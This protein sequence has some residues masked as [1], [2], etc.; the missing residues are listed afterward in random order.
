M[1]HMYPFIGFRCLYYILSKA[2]EA[3]LVLQCVK[4]FFCDCICVSIRMTSVQNN[5]FFF[6]EKLK[7]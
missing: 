7:T 1:I 3:I 2:E 6:H 4:F 5:D